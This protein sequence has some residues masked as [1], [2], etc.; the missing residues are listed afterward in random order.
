MRN[1]WSLL[2][3]SQIDIRYCKRGFIVKSAPFEAMT[4][5]KFYNFSFDTGFKMATEILTENIKFN[6]SV[7]NKPV[8]ITIGRQRQP[9]TT[10]PTWPLTSPTGAACGPS[11]SSGH[12]LG[13]LV[14][15][16]TGATP[17]PPTPGLHNPWL[18]PHMPSPAGPIPMGYQ[19]AKDPLTGQ[20]LLIPT[21]PSQG[22]TPQASPWPHQPHH[23]SHLHG[24]YEPFGASSLDRMPPGV[25]QSHY[26]QLYLQQ[27][28]HLRYYQGLSSTDPLQRSSLP[29]PH[30]PSVASAAASASSSHRP[31]LLHSPAGS[32][33]PKRHHESLRREPETITVSDDDDEVPAKTESKAKATEPTVPVK[34]PSPVPMNLAKSPQPSDLTI[35]KKIKQE[36]MEE[37]VEDLQTIA[38]S[39]LQL[40]EIEVKEEKAELLELLEPGFTA[41][42]KGI[43]LHE[44]TKDGIDMLCAVTQE[45]G[46]QVPYF[47]SHMT[48]SSRLD[49]LCCVTN[50]DK[51]DFDHYVDPLLVLKQNF[52]LHE[53]HSETSAKD[54]Q[55][56]IQHK[57]QYFKKLA[58]EP[59]ESFIDDQEPP[60]LAKILKKIK[61]TEFF[62]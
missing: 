41:L 15:P 46:Y 58:E 61:D 43:E 24:R 33:I 51:S 21:D 38:E 37:P 53:Y 13:S 19:L 16:P 57:A 40:S 62:R 60:S 30:V 26:Q 3:A 59:H 55:T 35:S 6:F 42:L 28:Q 14:P 22:P 45:D 4:L 52:N 9:G 49:V 8:G 23:P 1:Y 44:S 27:Q 36:P 34:I 12:H 18:P 39:L 5:K 10:A 2:L 31:D 17:L 11:Q 47:S 32:L 50:G 20:I 48:L 29:P 56:F 25:L 7:P 54:I